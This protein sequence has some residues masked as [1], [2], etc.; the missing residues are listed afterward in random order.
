MGNLFSAYLC[1]GSNVGKRGDYLELAAEKISEKCKIESKSNIYETE[2]VGPVAQAEFLNQVL[3]VQ[4]DLEPKKLLSFIQG[5]ENLLGRKRSF[6][7]APR[8]ID[9]DILLFDERIVEEPG[10][11]VPHPR[12]HER[13]FV[14]ALLLELKPNLVHP[15]LGVKIA[16][17]EKKSA[18]N[19]KIFKGS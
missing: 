14:L 18:G 10:L 15:R 6:P 5:I 4:T 13:R 3:H 1:L 8:T 9:I 12:M 16:D 19:I 7:Y 17:L 11:L 2:P